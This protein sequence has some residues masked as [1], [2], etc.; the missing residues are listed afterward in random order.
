MANI[1]KLVEE[2]VGLTNK[3]TLELIHELEALGFKAPEVQQQVVVSELPK[4]E[5]VKTSFD[6]ILESISTETKQKFETIKV[7]KAMG[8]NISLTEAKATLEAAPLN[9]AS[10]IS[11]EE[12]EVLK[13]QFE[14]LGA[15][16]KI[17]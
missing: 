15:K 16:V 9:L 2:I 10:G 14:G 7:Y 12:A 17:V 5:E 8:T 4:N 13:Q 1:K 6:V 3:E 11:K